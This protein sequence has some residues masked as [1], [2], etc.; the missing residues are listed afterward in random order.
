MTW[1][2]R[3]VPFSFTLPVLRSWQPPTPVIVISDEEEMAPPNYSVAKLTKPSSSR[4]PNSKL[5]IEK[6][7]NYFK[8]FLHR[9]GLYGVH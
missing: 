1:K 6:L 9:F 2:S 7:T 5:L 3:K 4:A 8:K